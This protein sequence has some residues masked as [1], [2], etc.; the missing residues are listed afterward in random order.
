[1]AK[2]KGYTECKCLVCGNKFAPAPFHVYKVHIRNTTKKVCS[3]HCM[4]EY[5]RKKGRLSERQA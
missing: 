3:Y 2:I 4:R 5:R 1:M